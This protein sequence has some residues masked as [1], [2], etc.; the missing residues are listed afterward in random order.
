M[1]RGYAWGF[2][3]LSVLSGGRI[4]SL[5]SGGVCEKEKALSVM[6]EICVWIYPNAAIQNTLLLRSKSLVSAWLA[7]LRTRLLGR[8]PE[9]ER[10]IFHLWELIFFGSHLPSSS[11]P[12]VYFATVALH[13]SFLHDSPAL[14][15]LEFYNIVDMFPRS[16]W[17]YD[18]YSKLLML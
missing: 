10:I 5:K 1:G 4:S 17:L 9:G 6:N 16:H 13:V 18:L 12:C 14:S 7:S 2:L 15:Q 8:Q 3:S 11:L